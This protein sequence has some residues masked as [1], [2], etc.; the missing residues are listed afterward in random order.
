M[1]ELRI[2]FSTLQEILFLDISHPL[3]PPQPWLVFLALMLFTN[4]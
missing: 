3:Q 2:Y 1:D 4:E